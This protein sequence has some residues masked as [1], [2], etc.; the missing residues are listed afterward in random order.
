MTRFI[1][2]YFSVMLVLTVNLFGCSSSGQNDLQNWMKEQRDAVRPKVEL[3]A[4]DQRFVI[5]AFF[6]PENSWDGSARLEDSSLLSSC[7]TYAVNEGIASNTMPS[8]MNS[9]AKGLRAWPM[10]G[11]GTKSTTIPPTR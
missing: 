5:G 1:F 6:P 2:L 3:S 10:M 9:Q 7:L 11:S 4:G 8:K